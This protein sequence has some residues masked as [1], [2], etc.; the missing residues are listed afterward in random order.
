MLMVTAVVVLIVVAVTV[1]VVLAHRGEACLARDG[2]S[3]LSGPG[4]RGEAC[5]ALVGLSRLSSS[6]CEARAISATASSKAAVLT[7][8]GWRKP[9]TLRTNWRAAAWTSSEVAG[10]STLRRVLMLRHMI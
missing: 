8:D 2:L 7:R 10:A 9:L 6:V 1:V 4:R 5:P 3:R